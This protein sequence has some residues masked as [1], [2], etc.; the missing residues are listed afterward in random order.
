MEKSNKNFRSTCIYLN[1]KALLDDFTYWSNCTGDL[2][3]NGK[4]ITESELP[5]EFVA[6]YRSLW[7]ENLEGSYCYLCAYKGVY[8]IALVNEYYEYTQDGKPGEVNNYNQALTAAAK[9]KNE[10]PEL[11]VFI[12]KQ[13]GY[14]NS[15]APVQDQA[16]ELFVF[17]PATVTKEHLHK[18]GRFLYANAYQTMA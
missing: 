12:G 9:V 8:G 1:E 11:D 4:D 16:T 15:S 5:A 13:T 14:L 3:H 2:H 17:M 6:A 18:V 7:E 10:Y